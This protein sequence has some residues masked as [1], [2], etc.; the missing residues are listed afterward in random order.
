MADWSSEEHRCY[1]AA[2]AAAEGR[3][4]ARMEGGRPAGEESKRWRD[5]VE[6]AQNIF[7]DQR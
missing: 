1:L 7:S 4:T 5:K 6:E 2:A 3:T